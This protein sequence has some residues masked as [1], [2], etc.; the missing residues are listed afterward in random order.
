MTTHYDDSFGLT[1]TWDD[2]GNARIRITGDLDWDTA[3]E[4][5]RTAADCLRT[6]PAPRRLRL[7]CEHLTLCDS[8]GLASLLMIH[9]HATEVGTRLH[10]T[11]RPAALQRLFETTG[12]S[13]VFGNAASDAH[14]TDRGNGGEQG[15]AAAAR[16]PRP[17][18]QP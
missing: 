6:E 3:A 2:N 9:R 13:H 8:L 17:P 18:A 5:T 7:D 16:A 10:L 12:T 14:D 15:H 11:N 4:L 1:T